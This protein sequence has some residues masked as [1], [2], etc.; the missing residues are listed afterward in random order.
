MLSTISLYQTIS[1][2]KWAEQIESFL[3]FFQFPQA[4]IKII[5]ELGHDLLTL[6][7]FEAVIYHSA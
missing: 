3:G 7:S 2:R 4:N 1:G 5:L 6:N